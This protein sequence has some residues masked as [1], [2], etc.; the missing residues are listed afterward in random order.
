MRDASLFSESRRVAM[1]CTAASQYSGFEAAN[2]SSSS[3]SD[4]S[5]ISSTAA[6][7]GLRMMWKEE[8]GYNDSY[9]QED[10][11]RRAHRRLSVTLD[12]CRHST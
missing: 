7:L 12:A 9:G 6:M 4:V 8:V 3:G 5:T 2:S 11:L 10:R 1:S